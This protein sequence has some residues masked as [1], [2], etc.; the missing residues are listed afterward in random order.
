MVW[1]NVLIMFFLPFSSSATA[2][3]VL[4]RAADPSIAADYFLE[5]GTGYNA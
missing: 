5:T 3:Y 2:I 4:S 1:S